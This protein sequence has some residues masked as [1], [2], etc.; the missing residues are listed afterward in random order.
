MPRGID[1]VESTLRPPKNGGPAY[2]A[3][4]GV[5]LSLPK[6]DS[7]FML[8]QLPDRPNLPGPIARKLT[9]AYERYATEPLPEHYDTFIRDEFEID[10][11]S[12]YAGFPVRSPFGKASG[13][14]SMTRRQ[15]EEDV[16]AGLGFVVLK[17][18][19]AQNETGEQS[20]SA[21][22][23]P[24][25]KMVVEPI[26]GR[27][28]E[29]GWTVSWKGRGWHRSFADYLQLIRDAREV[30]AES[31]CLIVPSCKYHLPASEGEGWNQAEYEYTTRHLWGAWSGDNADEA[32]PL[33]KD[34]S[35]TLA[36]DRLSDVR[37]QILRWLQEVPRLIKSSLPEP[38]RQIRLG[39]KLFNTLFDDEFQLELLDT[40]H[41]SPHRP[42]YFIYGNRLFDPARE[43][44]GKKGIAYGGPDLSDRNLFVLN[45]Y[46]SHSSSAMLP[47][48]ATGN[49][50]SGK[51]AV[52]YMLAGA[53]NFQLH[54]FFQLPA[55]EYT[56]RVGNKTHKAL[57]ELYF[58]PE[59][60]L[61][62]WLT[63]LHQQLGFE[64]SEISLRQLVMTIAN[65]PVLLDRNRA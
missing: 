22:A 55:K 6:P 57:H 62:A 15:V 3:P 47:L 61:L 11:A 10:L 9:E 43:F 46:R 59:L 32:M 54:T 42:D 44:E 21:W 12:E 17:T 25:T 53:E 50:D 8:V 45:R 24:E 38:A 29:R 28:G 48:S 35:P 18:V 39:L 52:E 19:I 40:I 31:G 63:H 14:L 16:N 33:E 2:C 49:I 20:M 41:N 1:A 65:R 13:Q 36:G 34:F 7:R 51:R 37:Q 58:H 60:G 5:F 26:T 56:C 30:A 23:S 64:S 4:H 27:S